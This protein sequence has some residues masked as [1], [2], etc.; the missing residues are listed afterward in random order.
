MP[1]DQKD[2]QSISDRLTAFAPADE[3]YWEKGYSN[4]YLRKKNE[5]F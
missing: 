2:L 3:I 5:I 1:C 4:V